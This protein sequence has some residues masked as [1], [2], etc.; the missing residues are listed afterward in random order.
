MENRSNESG[1][2]INGNRW[3]KEVRM[4]EGIIF[5]RYYEYGAGESG[6]SSFADS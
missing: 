3:I 1:G 2:M 5:K 4:I 6:D